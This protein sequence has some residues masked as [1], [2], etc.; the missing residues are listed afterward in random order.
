MKNLLFLLA[1]TGM[2]TSC[3]KWEIGQEEDE[4]SCPVI[5]QESIPKVVTDAYTAK[6]PSV[7]AEIWFDKNGTYVAA[8]EKDGKDMFAKFGSDGNFITEF[9]EDDSEYES[10][11]ECEEED[12]D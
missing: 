5:A 12:D 11:C 9:K 4:I 3:E 10:G 2:L 6:Y 7:S 1:V 8:F